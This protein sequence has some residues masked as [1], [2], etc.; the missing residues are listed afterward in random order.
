M[1]KREIG[2]DVSTKNHANPLIM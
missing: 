1:I 2:N